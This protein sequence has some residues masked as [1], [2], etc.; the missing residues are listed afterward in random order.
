[1]Q[2]AK[3]REQQTKA[4]LY[5]AAHRVS[6]TSVLLRRRRD[7]AAAIFDEVRHPRSFAAVKGRLAGCRETSALHLEAADRDGRGIRVVCIVVSRESALPRLTMRC[8]YFSLRDQRNVGS[9][10]SHRYL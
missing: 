8:D 9:P 3:R 7:F 6:V 2:D 10:A 5:K 1:M 4:T